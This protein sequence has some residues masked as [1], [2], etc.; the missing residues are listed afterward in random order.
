[1]NLIQYEQ[2]DNPPHA[3]GHVPPT[4]QALHDKTK[5]SIGLRL[6]GSSYFSPE[7]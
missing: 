7:N 1:M 6:K 2:G 3:L 5:N 4:Y